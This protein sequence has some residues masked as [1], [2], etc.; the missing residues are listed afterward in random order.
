MKVQ[1][2][3]SPACGHGE[4]ALELV[5]DVVRHSAPGTE[6]ETTLV[7]TAEDAARFSFPG[8][9][10]IRVNGRDIDPQ[11]PTNVGLG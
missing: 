10:T 5:A 7:A 2:L 9:P 1:V 8:S 4:R 6:I 3:M 11:P